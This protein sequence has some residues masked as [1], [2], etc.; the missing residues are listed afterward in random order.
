MR[1]EGQSSEG[2]PHVIQVD[3]QPEATGLGFQAR[4][5]ATSLVETPVVIPSAVEER[6][7]A[8]SQRP[9][10]RPTGVMERP[11]KLRQ[12]R[13]ALDVS[14]CSSIKTL[15]GLDKEW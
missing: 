11:V 7:V 8:Q 12:L 9:V 2:T 14:A 5:E 15:Q 1:P 4:G 3:E 13:R 10:R 6:P